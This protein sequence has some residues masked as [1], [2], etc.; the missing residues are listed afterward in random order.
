MAGIREQKKRE[1]RQAIL[2]AAIRLF[3]DKGYDK[4][5]IEDL[6]TEAGIGKTT[7]YGYFATKQE[8]F[9]SFCDEE[10]EYSFRT[11]RESIDR[12][13]PLLKQLV[14]LFMLQFQF[15]AENREFGRQL[16]R[17]LAFPKES[18]DNSLEHMQRY[19]Q[20]LEELLKASGKIKPEVNLATSSASFYMLYLGCLSGWYSGYLQDQQAV[21]ESMGRL[22]QQILEGIGL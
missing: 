21:E 17:E 19:L 12:D 13:A 20:T 5:S 8:I 9:Q 10:I 3:G 15:I 2:D 4:T 1:T 22:F 6:A 11:I 18:S 7:I 16:I 14:A